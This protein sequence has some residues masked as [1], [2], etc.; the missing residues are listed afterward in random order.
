M[1]KTNNAKIPLIQEMLYT[2]YYKQH[3][4]K[5]RAKAKE[6]QLREKSIPTKKAFMKGRLNQR[7][8]PTVQPLEMGHLGADARGALSP[9]V[10]LRQMDDSRRVRDTDTSNVA[11]RRF[12][13]QGLPVI[14][15][16]S[17]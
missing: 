5:A 11:N 14:W 12:Q 2:K 10:Q 1:I 9:A 7:N 4:A 17:A 13:W 15:G 6:K 8:L 3:K 16:D